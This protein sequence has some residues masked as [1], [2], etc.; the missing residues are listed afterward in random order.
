MEEKIEK[1]SPSTIIRRRSRGRDGSERGHSP[2]FEFPRIEE[3]L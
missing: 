3:I 1:D 2:D